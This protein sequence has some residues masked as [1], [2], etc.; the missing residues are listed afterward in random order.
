[1]SYPYRRC[2]PILFLLLGFHI[3]GQAEVLVTGNIETNT[4]WDASANP[5]VITTAASASSP[6]ELINVIAGV[7]LTINPGVVIEIDGPVEIAVQG[8][9]VA[10][11]TAG[12]PILVRPRQGGNLWRSITFDTTAV[13]AVFDAGGN[14]LSGSILEYV[15]LTY[16][17]SPTRYK[18]AQLPSIPAFGVINLDGA[19]PYL[20]HV[21]VS[22]GGATGIYAV[23]IDGQLKIEN[24]TITGN[25]ESTI[26]T[27][28][29]VK[30]GGGVYLAGLAAGGSDFQLTHNMITSNTSQ[31]S[32]GGIA[33][34]G[35]NAVIRDNVISDNMTLA[36]FGGGIYLTGNSNVQ[37]DANA[38][39]LNYAEYEGGGIY[40]NS[41]TAASVAPV[42]ITNNAITGNDT[43]S[44]G[45]GLYIV[46][47]SVSVTGNIIADNTAQGGDI[48]AMEIHAGGTLSQ[49]SVVRNQSNSILAV[50]G[51]YDTGAGLT[52]L[53]LQ[54]N[55]ISGN[56]SSTNVIVNTSSTVPTLI[57]NNIVA[58][59]LGFFITNVDLVTTTLP[60]TNNYFAVPDAL[61]AANMSGQIDYTMAAQNIFTAV[62]LTPPGNFTISRNGGSLSLTW[63]APPEPDVAGY[64]VYWGNRRAPGYENAVDVGNALSYVMPFEDSSQD[65][66]FAVAA[67]DTSYN[68]A[69][70]DDPATYTIESQSAGNESW[71]SQERVIAGVVPSSGGGGGGSLGE[72]ALLLLLC[73]LAYRRLASRPRA[74]PSMGNQEYLR[75]N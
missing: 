71:F 52:A 26:Y 69:A 12:N 55:N 13:S 46:K 16:G 58:N 51:S 70:V 6:L 20:N 11:G 9:L 59:G 72:G 23:D 57:G 53:N 75:K 28:N 49:N 41:T 62:P 47:D 73:L 45:G 24:C 67:Y 10:R 63:S 18:S 30:P 56:V 27:D 54:D 17:G 25:Y 35:A 8:T 14:Y 38:I 29:S 32:G 50:A 4:T 22:D 65:T 2:L 7:T 39:T 37:I 19:R 40:V 42:V 61:L 1:M 44:R 33:L 5:Y 34:V 64:I 74:R 66:Y 43:A 15:Q 31:G 21:T 60:A 68:G 3:A 48:S 36:E